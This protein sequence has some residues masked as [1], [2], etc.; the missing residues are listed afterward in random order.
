MDTE[1]SSQRKG[2]GSK[3]RPCNVCPSFLSITP[4]SSFQRQELEEFKQKV[5][6]QREERLLQAAQQSS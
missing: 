2:S 5:R 3:S 4:F 1:L 6:K